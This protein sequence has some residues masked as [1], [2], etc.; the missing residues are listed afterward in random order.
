M[1]PKHTVEPE[2]TGPTPR[3][4]CYRDGWGAG[5]VLWFVRLFLLPHALAGVIIL[6]MALWS[7]GLYLG[8]GLFGD[9]Y[10]AAVVKKSERRGSK[11]KVFYSVEYE[12]MVAGRI[13]TGQVSVSAVE[14]Q[15]VA[16]GDRFAVRA[17]ES[18]PTSEPWV[19]MP[20]QAPRPNVGGKWLVAVFWNGIMS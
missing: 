1:V 13:H 7:T 11:G 4:T 14:Y 19:R 9:E 6:G 17:L 18:A 15:Q 3:A 12:Y 16:E 8:I 5:C 20:G 10:E 2:L